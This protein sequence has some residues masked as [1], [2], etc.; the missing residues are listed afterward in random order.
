MGP[1][2]RKRGAWTLPVICREFGAV[3]ANVQVKVLRGVVIAGSRQPAVS[4]R[5]V[6]RRGAQVQQTGAENALRSI[7]GD[8]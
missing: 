7:A 1:M 5:Y 6:R 4:R 2:I 3:N 8:K